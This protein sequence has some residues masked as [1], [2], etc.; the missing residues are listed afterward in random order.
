MCSAWPDGKASSRLPKNEMPWTRPST[1]LRSGRVRL[2]TSF[3]PCGSSDAATVT[4]TA[5][6]P[7]RRNASPHPREASQPA[8]AKTR[9]T[10]SS[11]PHVSARAISSGEAGLVFL[12]TVRATLTSVSVGRTVIGNLGS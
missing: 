1:V 11:A 7:A 9:R 4:S 6:L 8:A 10:F 5:W 3:S 12:A 2:N